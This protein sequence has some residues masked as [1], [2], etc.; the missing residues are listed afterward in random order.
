MDIII[1]KRIKELMVENNLNQSKLSESIGI[2]QGTISYWLSG[3]KEP[4]ITS[5]WLLADFFDVDID[6]LVGR[7]D[8]WL[9]LYSP[10]LCP[11][12]KLPVNNL[13]KYWHL[14]QNNGII[15]I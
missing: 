13:T 8:Y 6:Y 4:S 14:T 10:I 2:K 15:L 5:L 1:A 12:S 11:Q 3:K 7:K 9:Q